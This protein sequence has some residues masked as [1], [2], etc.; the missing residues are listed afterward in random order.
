MVVKK[1]SWFALIS[2]ILILSTVLAACGGNNEGTV[3]QATAVKK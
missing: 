2:L 3:K 1:K